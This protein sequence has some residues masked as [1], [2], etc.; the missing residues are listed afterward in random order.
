MKE[1]ISLGTVKVFHGGGIDAA[2]A[3]FGG[4]FDDWL[5]L[6]TGINP[7]SYALPELPLNLWHRLPDENVLHGALKAARHF[8]SSEPDAPLVAAPG[9]QSLIQNLPLLKEAGNMAILTPTYQEYAAS[10]ERSGW[11]VHLCASLADIPEDVSVVVV[12]NPNNPDGRYISVKQLLSL[13]RVLA[14]RGGFLVVDE[15][16]GDVHEGASMVPHAQS[17]ALIVLKSFGKFFGLAGVRLGFAF[18]GAELVTK[19]IGRLGPWAVSGPALAVAQAA[20]TDEGLEAF[21][22]RIDVR[23]EGLSA[24]FARTNIE[25]IGGTA[26]FSLVQSEQAHALWQHLAEQKILVRKFDYA[27][28]WLRVGLAQD[29]DDLIRLENAIT[30]FKA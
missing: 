23:R 3:H 16:F 5:D 17:E 30:T 7:E 18:S 10:F 24:I 4:E 20:F 21:R 13:A 11:N 2:M 28:H 1:P 25:E 15:A 14:R 22:R 26:L 8:Y 29:A 19:L 27:P 12:V 6:S 9:T